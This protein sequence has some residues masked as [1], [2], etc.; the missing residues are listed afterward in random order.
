[1]QEKRRKRR[2]QRLGNGA[3]FAAHRAQTVSK[4]REKLASLTKGMSTVLAKLQGATQSLKN[5]QDESTS[6]YGPAAECG[7]T[8][9]EAWQ[10]EV[11]LPAAING[12]GEPDELKTAEEK[13]QSSLSS[14]DV[15]LAK[16]GENLHCNATL[17]WHV[18][19]MTEIDELDAL[20]QAVK[21]MKDQHNE[22]EV[23]MKGLSKICADVASFM[24]QKKRKEVRDAE[25]KKKKAEQEALT[26]VKM[27]AKQHAE[28]IKSG[29]AGGHAIFSIPEDKLSKMSQRKGDDIFD[30][31]ALKNIDE[32]WICKASSAA[33]T[34]RNSA[35]VAVK[36]SEFAGNYKKAQSFKDNGRAQAI[37]LPKQGKEET[38]GFLDN[39]FSPPGVDVSSVDGATDAVKNIWYWG[40]D[41]KLCGAWLA[42]NACALLKVLVMGE[43]TL[44][45]ANLADL[46][47]ALRSSKPIEEI[48]SDMVTSFFLSLTGKAP[49][50]PKI[51]I[52]QTTMQADDVVY[53]PTGWLIAERSSSTVKVYGVRK[54]L[55]VQSTNARVSFAAAVDLLSRSNRDSSKMAAILKC[56]PE[57]AV[58]DEQKAPEPPKPSAAAEGVVAAVGPTV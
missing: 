15:K 18:M 13:F 39:F 52:F 7:L 34:W 29:Q 23:L 16:S 14:G 57:D 4:Q 58:K 45:A 2:A 24:S 51:K 22:V 53:V 26:Q 49:L 21:S 48:T 55:F 43:L 41:P 9:V 44:L 27:Q 54:S 11:S 5:A 19:Q 32:P 12:Q 25:Q 6:L 40:Y 33:S 56:Y 20:D 50:F 47:E 30:A 36:L 8:C 31:K 10:K 1:M 42:P 28:A 37:M 17:V 35:T 38:E 3:S 46:V